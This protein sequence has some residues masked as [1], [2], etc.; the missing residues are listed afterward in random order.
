MLYIKKADS[1]NPYEN[2]W[3]ATC[4][5]ESDFTIYIIGDKHL[6]HKS[7]GIVQIRRTRLTD[8]ARRTGVYYNVVD[9][10]DPIRSK[11]VFMYYASQYHP[12]QL[13][14]I[15]REWNGGSNGMNKKSTIKYWKLIQTRL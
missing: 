8:Y 5:V 2:I 14:K 4:S 1:I 15:A 12:L 6:R 3:N 13:E 9:M 10:F 11:E 7:Y